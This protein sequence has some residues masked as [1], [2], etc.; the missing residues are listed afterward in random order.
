MIRAVQKVGGSPASCPVGDDQVKFREF[1]VVCLAMY[2]PGCASRLPLVSNDH[3]TVTSAGALPPPDGDAASVLGQIYVFGPLDR[4][5]IA[6]LG[7]NELTGTFQA[8]TSGRIALPLIGAITITGLT[9]QQLQEEL[10]R[11]LRGAYVHDPNVAVN[12]AEAVSQRFTIEGQVTEPG[13]YPAVGPTTLIQAIAL[14]KGTTEF[15]KLD[16][17]VIFRMVNSRQMAALYNVGAIERGAYEDPRIYARDIIV[18]G[19][20]QA[21]RMFKD[22]LQSSTLLTAPLIAFTR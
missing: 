20:S 18:V 1:A 8:D 4:V 22:V 11:R 9:P 12:L 5:S 17:V 13:I 2:L 3:L 6:V 14:A 7:V 15:A 21:R 19:D 10:G 16:D